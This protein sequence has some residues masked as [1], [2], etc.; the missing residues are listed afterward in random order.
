MIAIGFVCNLF[1][2][3]FSSL[4]VWPCGLVEFELIVRFPFMCNQMVLMLLRLM[5]FSSLLRGCARIVR[6]G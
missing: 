5:L 1:L 4:V 2:F 3:Y 6:N